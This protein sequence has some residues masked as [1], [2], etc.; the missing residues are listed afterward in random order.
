MSK[1]GLSYDTG[2]TI[3]QQQRN[4]LNLDNSQRF[5]LYQK[6]K[7]ADDQCF[8]EVKT[9]QSVGPGQYQTMNFY[10]C[11]CLIPKTA[12]IAT[13]L[14]MV[15]YKNGLDVA[16]CVVDQS[17]DLRVGKTK[18]FPKCPQQLFQRPYLTTP[19][20]QRGAGNPALESQ[21]LPGEAT[22]EKRQCNTLSGI[23][24]PHYFTPLVDHLAYN[25]Q[26]PVHLIEEVAEPGWIRSGAASRLVVR[27]IDYLER[28]GAQY[29]DKVM[30]AEFW[31]D[32][33]NYL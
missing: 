14:P 15:F 33:H 10:D 26:N 22:S 18:R 12:K 27:D 8:V 28:C 17:T 31:K 11:E 21:L 1:N 3:L 5:N 23:T 4:C 30:N 9:V 7:S 29:Q 19:G 24:I 16:G 2:N 20:M 25:V 32:K 6:T 13:D